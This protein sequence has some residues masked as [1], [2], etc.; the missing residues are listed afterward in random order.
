MKQTTLQFK[1]EDTE[2]DEDKI[3]QRKKTKEN[4]GLK[5]TTK[6]IKKADKPSYKRKYL[7][8]KIGEKE[9]GKIKID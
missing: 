1:P 6:I 8:L 2:E 3:T 9:L 7:H 5:R 4:S